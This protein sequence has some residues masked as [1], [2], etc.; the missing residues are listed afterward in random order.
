MSH[1]WKSVYVPPYARFVYGPTKCYFVHMC[2]CSSGDEGVEDSVFRRGSAPRGGRDITAVTDAGVH[3]V[4][5][6]VASKFNFHWVVWERSLQWFC[7]I[8]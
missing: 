2:V 8:W 3:A 1:Q 5:P 4:D 7:Y 6:F